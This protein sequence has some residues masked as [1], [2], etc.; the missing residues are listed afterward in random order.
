MNAK[1]ISLSFQAHKLIIQKMITVVTFFCN[2]EK[3]TNFKR[4]QWAK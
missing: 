2:K 1:L 3:N 4:F